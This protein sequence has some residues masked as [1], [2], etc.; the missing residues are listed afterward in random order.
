[1]Q[2]RAKILLTIII[3]I[4]QKDLLYEYP[5]ANKKLTLISSYDGIKDDSPFL[6]RFSKFGDGECGK[7][8]QKTYSSDISKF[9]K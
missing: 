4:H 6:I 9:S 3:R 1:M 7:T 5:Q 8:K 2:L